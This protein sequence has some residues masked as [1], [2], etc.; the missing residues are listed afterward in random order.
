MDENFYDIVETWPRLIDG[1][2]CFL[3]SDEEDM[4]RVDEVAPEWAASLRLA[5]I[6]TLVIY[7]LKAGD[8]RLYLGR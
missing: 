5:Q 8:D 1:S 3:I 2:N 6:K 4:K 7:A